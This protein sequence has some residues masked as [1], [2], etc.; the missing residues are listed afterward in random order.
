MP[1]PTPG[2]LLSAVTAALPERVPLRPLTDK[3]LLTPF[4][5]LFLVLFGGTLLA[6]ALWRLA[7]EKIQHIVFQRDHAVRPVG[8]GH[9]AIA[10][11]LPAPLGI[12]GQFRDP[13]HGTAS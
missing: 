1:M 8:P 9:G 4:R 3:V 12:R 11:V 7:P 5:S 6:L 10:R 2:A 13:I